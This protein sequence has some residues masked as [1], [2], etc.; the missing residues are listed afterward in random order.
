M[1]TNN[2]EDIAVKLSLFQKVG[3]GFGEAGSTLSFT[4][5]SSYLT[6]FYSDVVGLAPAIIAENTNSKWGRYR[7]YILFGAP[8]LAVFNCLTF[9]NLNISNGAKAFWCVFTYIVCCTAYS[10]ANG[11]VICVVNSITSINAERVS[12]NAYKGAIG[13][14][15]S[16]IVNAVTMPLLLYFG[17][18]NTNS[19][20]GYFMTAL[21]FSIASLPCFFLCFKSTKEVISGEKQNTEGK[22]ESGSQ[23]SKLI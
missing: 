1:S 19:S 20:N 10:F 7:P 5:I 14:I 17:H 18:G 23:Y 15:F 22:K 11:A 13:S 12:A 3:Y 21:I 9:L 4:L 6:V 16:V 8:V 2:K